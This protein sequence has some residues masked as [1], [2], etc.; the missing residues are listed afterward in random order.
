MN[1]SSA[2]DQLDNDD[3]TE[4]RLIIF[5][6]QLLQWQRDDLLS[7]LESTLLSHIREQQRLNRSL[8]V[9][10]SRPTWEAFSGRVSTIHFRRM[11]RMTL[12]V[13]LSPHKLECWC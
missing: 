6:V 2:A 9:E 10:K 12:D 7:G 13:S 1:S 4:I 11:F 8:P 3:M 5:I